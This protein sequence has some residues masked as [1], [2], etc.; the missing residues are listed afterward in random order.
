VSYEWIEHTAEVELAV[1]AETPSGVFEEALRALAELAGAASGEP[2]TRAVALEAADLP[3][4]LVAWLEEILYLEETES[5]VFDEADVTVSGAASLAA[6]LRGRRGEPR[7][8]VKA[9]TYHGL[10]I[11]ERDG[12]WIARVVLDV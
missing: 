9:V 11:A 12:Q 6:K 2:I 1:E 5:C 8:L 10:T 4:L 7:P 3:A